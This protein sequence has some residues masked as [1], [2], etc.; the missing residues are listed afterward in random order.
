MCRNRSNTNSSKP[1]RSKQT[2]GQRHSG[3]AKSACRSRARSEA[4][5]TSKGARAAVSLALVVPPFPPPCD[6]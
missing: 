2:S 1:N 4:W 5:P 3:S 6:I